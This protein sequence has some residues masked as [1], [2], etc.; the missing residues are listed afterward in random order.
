MDEAGD[1][2]Y[3][4]PTDVLVEI[5]LRLPPSSRRRV[6]LV[7]QLWRAAVDDRTPEMQLRAVKTLVS[8]TNTNRRPPTASAYVAD[9][10][11]LAEPRFREVWTGSGDMRVIA[12]C[13]GLICVC[14][15]GKPGGALTLVNPATGKTLAVPPLPRYASPGQGQPAPLVSWDEAYSFGYHPVT[16]RYKIVYAPIAG[17]LDVVHVFTLG[18]AAWRSVPL[19]AAA[20]AS[21]AGGLVSFD[22][23]T[24]WLG[25]GAETMVSFDL[26]DEKLAAWPL[27]MTAKT[28]DS[29]RLMVVRGKLGVAVDRIRDGTTDVW[30]LEGRRWRHRYDVQLH[31]LARPTSPHFVH[32]EYVLATKGSVLYGHRLE[33]GE[34]RRSMR[35]CNVLRTSEPVP[36]VSDFGGYI[37][38]TFA[39]AETT[40][41]LGVYEQASVLL[42]DL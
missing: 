33:D 21:G 10:L 6:R 11:P 30:V 15:N 31:R 34:A 1:H 23:A 4:F 14:D 8:V 3:D 29:F 17:S 18:E 42:A 13:N 9:D 7:C 28:G 37:H 38:R 35:L 25:S 2:K 20:R 27:P 5:L 19:P 12:S 24:Y 22:G 39:Y 32:G 40:E 41:P 16:G 36:A 26:G